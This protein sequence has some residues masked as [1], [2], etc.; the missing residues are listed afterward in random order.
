[1]RL[2]IICSLLF[3]TTIS[4]LRAD[5][6]KQATPPPPAV[7]MPVYHIAPEDVLD[8]VVQDHADLSKTTVVLPDGTMSYPYVGEFKASGLTLREITD[9]IT[10]ALSK[11]IS[12]PQVIVTIKSLHE[13]PASQ[14]SII[15]AAHS[16]GKH[17]LKEGWRVLDLLIESGGLPV[18]HLETFSASIIR[19]GSEIIPVDL[20]RIFSATDIKANF[21]LMPNDLL[22]VRDTTAAPPAT[23]V[24]ILGEVNRP[25]TVTIPKDGSIVAMIASVGGPT[26]RAALSKATITHNGQ[27]KIV[28]LSGFLSEGKIPASIKLEAGDTLFV[29]QNKLSFSVYGAV[30]HPG[31]M[32]YPETQ[33]LTALTALALAGG[34]A[35]NANLKAV[36]VTHPSPSGK[37]TVTQINLDNVMKNGDLTKDVPVQPGDI[38]FIPST[39]SKNNFSLGNVFS[40]LTIARLLGF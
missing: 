17:I 3:L 30:A 39:K 34:H 20:P 14:V 8:I 7:E 25:G 13:R 12:G 37:P 23:Q 21:L 5:E 24:E 10:R 28:D 11:E 31:P 40:A 19:N 32:V 15:G 1:M 26:S 4:G 9:R 16:T 2:P 35:G 29:P 6:V 22:V 27:T 38:L 33:S 18:D 36:T